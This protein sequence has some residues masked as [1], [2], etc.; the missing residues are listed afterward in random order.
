ML[1]PEPN[2]IA[3]SSGG[4]L[5]IG[6]FDGVHLGHQRMIEVLTAEARALG[7]PSVAMTFDPPPAA[8]LRPDRVPPSL[9]T[10]RQRAE[11]LKTYGVDQVIIWPTSKELLDLGPEEFFNEIIVGRLQARGMVEGPNFCFGKDRAGDVNT[12]TGFCSNSDIAL[13][14]VVPV[15]DSEQL[16]SSSRIRKLVADGS[17][18]D[19]VNLLGHPYQICGEVVK[20]AGRGRT[21]GVPTANISGIPTL[22]PGNGVYAGFC[23]LDERQ[24]V[25][26]INIGENPTFGDDSAKVEVHIIGLDSDLYGQQFTVSLIA[27]IREVRQFKSVVQLTDQISK[28]IESAQGICAQYRAKQ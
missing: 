14:V 3:A 23:D 28:D 10:P 2:V 5:A 1:L 16:V 20:G 8:L 18:T 4:V 13:K 26:A 19:A 27:E 24:Y 11:L 7:A 12:L 21:I 17:I 25:C 22:I 15:Q 6:N 9:T